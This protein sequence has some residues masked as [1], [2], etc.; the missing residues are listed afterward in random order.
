MDFVRSSASEPRGIKLSSSNV[1]YNVEKV[2]SSISSIASSWN[3]RFIL[4]KAV[5]SPLELNVGG[6]HFCTTID[7]YAS[8]TSKFEKFYYKSKDCSGFTVSM[9]RMG[10]ISTQGGVPPG[11]PKVRPHCGVRRR[12]TAAGNDIAAHECT[13][14]RYRPATLALDARWYLA[15]I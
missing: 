6:I 10:R 5:H 9:T 11:F 3:E 7:S 12:P 2:I 1:S 15:Y 4:I 8:A 13:S 14:G